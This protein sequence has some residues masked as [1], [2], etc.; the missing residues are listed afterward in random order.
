[1][2]FLSI[3][4]FWKQFEKLSHPNRAAL[5]SWYRYKNL[6]FLVVL[7]TTRV[8][9][10]D[11][12]AFLISTFST[13]FSF[14]YSLLVPWISQ[15]SSLKTLFLAKVRNSG[16]KAQKS[17]SF[18]LRI[19]IGSAWIMW[20]Q[21]ENIAPQSGLPHGSQK[22]KMRTDIRMR[23]PH[24]P[25]KNKASKTSSGSFLKPYLPILMPWKTIQAFSKLAQSTMTRFPCKT[26]YK[27]DG[28]APGIIFRIY[29]NIR[30]DHETVQM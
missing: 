25:W 19:T 9:Q 17:L 22:R 27:S 1:M 14:L 18:H 26:N 23:M 20:L 13:L 8:K 29:I 2:W 5:F 21:F 30:Q 12:P 16:A 4:L 15:I 28:F 10:I 24:P 11:Y 7:W 3:F 6:Q